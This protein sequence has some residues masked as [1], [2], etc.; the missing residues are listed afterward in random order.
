MTFMGQAFAKAIQ[1]GQIDRG[2]DVFAR[3]F[4][5]HRCP[6]YLPRN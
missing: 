6:R 2:F 4:E 1:E 3:F 5:V